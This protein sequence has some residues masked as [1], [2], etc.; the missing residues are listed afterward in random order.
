MRRIPSSQKWKWYNKDMAE[1]YM[2][3]SQELIPQNFALSGVP[4]PENRLGSREGYEDVMVHELNHVLA[5]REE[6]NKIASVTA[7][8][9]VGYLG[10][11]VL[12]ANKSL[13]SLAVIAAAGSVDT[14]FGKAEGYGSDMNK[15]TIIAGFDKGTIYEYKRRARGAVGQY[16]PTLRARLAELLTYMEVEMGIEITG[17]VF[18]AALT[19]AQQE[20]ALPPQHPAE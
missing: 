19:R 11:T 20:L 15:V 14:V 18:E 13:D 3:T 17:D 12:E 5:A 16:S 7:L 1:R 9:G 2:P 4:M 6:G 8:P 10:L